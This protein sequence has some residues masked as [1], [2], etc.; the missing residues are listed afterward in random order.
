MAFNIAGDGTTTSSVAITAL[1]FSNSFPIIPE[2]YTPSGNTEVQ[3]T[4]SGFAHTYSLGNR[5]RSWEIGL[6]LLT[7]VQRIAIEKLYDELAGSAHWATWYEIGGM[8]SGGAVGYL[9]HAST[10]FTYTDDYRNSCVLLYSGTGSGQVR[11]CSTST[12]LAPGTRF[13]VSPSFG[14]APVASDTLFLIGWPVR[15]SGPLHIERYPPDLYNVD[16]RFEE[17]LLVGAG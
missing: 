15:F 13:A 17:M 7:A 3:V 14:T 1:S 5:Q 11:R 9:D 8:A 6:R 16:F 12:N 2:P 10:A 4:S